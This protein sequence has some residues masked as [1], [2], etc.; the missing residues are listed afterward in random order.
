M[1]NLIIAGGDRRERSK[2]LLE[3]LEGRQGRRW[4][5]AVPCGLPHDPPADV[6]GVGLNDLD[7][8]LAALGRV[9]AGDALAVE[10][11][12]RKMKTCPAL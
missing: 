4:L 3:R 9:R 5:V 6:R 11:V 7:G 1:P 10:S 12:D 8:A 2:T